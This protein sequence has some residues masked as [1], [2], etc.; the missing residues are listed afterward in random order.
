M[1]SHGGF[2]QKSLRSRASGVIWTLLVLLVAT[3][4]LSGCGGSASVSDAAMS[5]DLQTKLNDYLHTRSAVEHV[6]AVSL[7]VN[8]RGAAQNINAVAGTTK[9]GGT[10]D[11]TPSTLFQVGS[12]TKAFTAATIL[13]LEAEG[14]LTIHDTLG[15]WLLQYP[16]WSNVTIEHLLDMTS[17]IPDYVGQLAYAQAVFANP[18]QIFTAEQLVAFIPPSAPPTTGFSYSNTNYILA[19]MIIEKASDSHDYATEIDRRFI[20]KLHLGDTFY[21]SER[22]PSAVN[23]RLV[24]GYGFNTVVFGWAD[25]SPYN[26]SGMQG[27]GGIVSTPEDQSKWIRALYKGNVLAPAQQRELLSIVSISTGQ[28]LTQTSQN[29]NMGFGLGVVQEYNP[30]LGAIV[31]QYRGSTLGYRFDY[32]WLPAYDTVIVMGANSQVFDSSDAVPFQ[33]LMKS[34]FEALH[35]AGRL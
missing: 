35:A 6:S 10:V 5:A 33:T 15:Q 25:V 16:Q 31:W 17:G 13:Q 7:S 32:Y 8:I 26:L 29:D 14:K 34:V 20:S 23:A 4:A 12:N 30:E 27:A 18:D 1:Q 22:L 3:I 24:S 9:Y 28:P 19:Q 11:I 21:S 2:L